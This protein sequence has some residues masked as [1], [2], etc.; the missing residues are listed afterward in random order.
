M[1]K[2]ER[3]VERELLPL[4]LPFRICGYTI[5]NSATIRLNFIR[6]DQAQCCHCRTAAN[7]CYGR[8]STQTLSSEVAHL[9]NSCVGVA[10]HHLDGGADYSVGEGAS[11]RLRG[12]ECGKSAE[13]NGVQS[14]S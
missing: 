8:F 3:F 11:L 13:T 2:N 12:S 5:L 14:E 10:Q 7:R 4:R 9:D 6:R 1:L